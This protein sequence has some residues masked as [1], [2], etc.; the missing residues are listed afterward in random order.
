MTTELFKRVRLI[1]CTEG[2]EDKLERTGILIYGGDRRYSMAGFDSMVMLDPDTDQD[3]YDREF[4]C[5]LAGSW[6]PGIERWPEEKW[7]NRILV[8]ADSATHLTIIGLAQID[9]DAGVVSDPPAAV[10][11]GNFNISAIQ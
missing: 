7:G 9:I 11:D 2:D 10:I 1:A 3:D 4:F 5:T 6:F 8:E